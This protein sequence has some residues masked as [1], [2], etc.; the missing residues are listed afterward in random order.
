[1]LDGG[2][3]SAGGNGPGTVNI[4][5][6][7]AEIP[8]SVVGSDAFAGR[9]ELSGSHALGAAN[10]RLAGEDAFE[11]SSV[12]YRKKNIW[13]QWTAP[14]TGKA[15]LDTLDSSSGWEWTASEDGM[16]T[17]D[18]IGSSLLDASGGEMNTAVKVFIGS[19]LEDLQEIATNNDITGSAWSRVSFFAIWGVAYQIVVDGEPNSAYGEG[20]IVLNFNRAPSPE[21]AIQQP[22]GSELSDGNSVKSIGTAKIGTKRA[23]KTFTIRNAGTATLSGLSISPVRKREQG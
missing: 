18:T 19:N 23:A 5:L 21:I 13:W 8:P 9:L 11:P 6:T 22:V 16:I 2:V 17:I 1:M 4:K 10:N 15:T 14:A 7:P 20:N 12:G 3:N